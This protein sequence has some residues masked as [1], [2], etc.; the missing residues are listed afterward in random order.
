VLEVH[1]ELPYHFGGEFA[2]FSDYAV[3]PLCGAE[4]ALLFANH[5]RITAKGPLPSMPRIM[6]GNRSK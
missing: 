2:A 6:S 3:A 4:R 5:S 1:L